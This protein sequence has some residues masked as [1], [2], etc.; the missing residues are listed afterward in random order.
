[1]TMTFK[2]AGLAAAL[3][4]TTALVAPSA[5][6]ADVTPSRSAATSGPRSSATEMFAPAA[7]SGLNMRLDVGLATG[8]TSATS[9]HFVLMN[10]TTVRS[11]LPAVADSDGTATDNQARFVRT[12]PP[13]ASVGGDYDGVLVVF[14]STDVAD[15]VGAGNQAAII[16]PN[17]TVTP[18]AD[19]AA[20]IAAAQADASLITKVNADYA[21][22]TIKTANKAGNGLFATFNAVP[23]NMPAAN[24]SAAAHLRFETAAGVAQNPLVRVDAGTATTLGADG[25]LTYAFSKDGTA[26]AIDIDAARVQLADA[27]TATSTTLATLTD[28]AGNGVVL[29]GTSINVPVT[30]LAA[31]ALASGTAKAV[32]TTAA[33]TIYASNGTNTA[34]VTVRFASNVAGGADNFTANA[35]VEDDFRIAPAGRVTVNALNATD[36]N[37][38]IS[39]TTSTLGDRF[40]YGADGKLYVFDAAQVPA[41]EFDPAN[42]TANGGAAVTVAVRAADTAANRL[43]TVVGAQQLAAG[44]SLDAGTPLAGTAPA[45]TA[46]TNDFDASGTLDGAKLTFGAPINATIPAASGAI[47]FKRGGSVTTAADV[48]ATTAELVAG[49]D[50][51]VQLKSTD[52]AIQALV[53]P[54]TEAAARTSTGSTGA[55]GTT[56]IPFDVALNDSTIAYTNVYAA[57]GDRAGELAQVRDI[58]A[59]TT[60]GTAIT[61]GAAPILKSAKLYTPTGSAIEGN[62]ELTFSEAMQTIAA[63]DAKKFLATPSGTLQVDLVNAPNAGDP[64]AVD[65]AKLA[66]GIITLTGVDK[67]ILDTLNVA[68]G[69]GVAEGNNSVAVATG[70]SFQGA[71]NNKVAPKKVTPGAE[72]LKETVK[73]DV[74]AT[75]LDATGKNVTDILVFLTSNV[76][77]KVATGAS[78]A[79][80][81]DVDLVGTPAV[82]DI[83]PASVSVTDNIL[84]IK[85]AG[86]GLTLRQLD[87]VNGINVDYTPTA[88]TF[89]HKVGDDTNKITAQNDIQVGMPQQ[90]RNIFSMDLR[91]R[92][93]TT[94]EPATATT[95]V[96]KGSIVRADVVY[97][98]KTNQVADRINVT[99]PCDCGT[100]GTS[101]IAGT[102][103]AVVDTLITNAKNAG[104]I[105][106][107]GY[108]VVTKTSNA[109][110]SND[111]AGVTA[112]VAAAPAA[113]A[114]GVVSYPISID[115]RNGRITSAERRISG[116]VYFDDNAAGNQYKVET[117]STSYGI[118]D[119]DGNYR[120]TVGVEDN[121][122]NAFVSLA[123]KRPNKTW[124]L[125]SSA[126][127]SFANHIPFKTDMLV[128]SATSDRTHGAL[129]GLDEFVKSGG[130]NGQGV[131][132]MRLD[133]IATT[134]V[135]KV[136][137]TSGASWQTV[138]FPGELARSRSLNDFT[139]FTSMVTINQGSGAPI[140]LWSLD[141]AGTT[142]AGANVEDE[143]FVLWG[144]RA[145]S[146][147]E[148]G[149]SQIQNI[150][151]NFTSGK[152]LAVRFGADT[153]GTIVNTGTARTDG[154]FYMVDPTKSVATVNLPAGWSLLTA[155]KDEDL[156]A[157]D[158]KD[159]LAMVVEAGAGK[160][161]RTWIK[162]AKGNLL[163]SMEKGKAY[164]VYLERAVNNAWAN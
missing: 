52:A 87:G 4:A 53:S 54:A 61:D 83:R 143:A 36:A 140:G 149:A 9:V 160:Q 98:T 118:V 78:L 58:H 49:S 119:A 96:E 10:G 41:V 122:D 24:S 114:S 25:I 109:A 46:S 2:K 123:V 69:V 21:G 91:G 5:F 105:S 152:G 132:N 84:T 60:Y 107:N 99:V 72:A 26:S 65:G 144:N 89:L 163:N 142:A 56:Q 77:A 127:K 70:A 150:R 75:V 79:D 138:G 121:V 153:A 137:G 62:V 68:N 139:A 104:Q 141:R 39:L 23:A 93:T 97:F 157:M 13:A 88:T 116:T 16:A 35:G 108:L 133:A 64:I 92:L 74:G 15:F 8:S 66:D 90:T 55:A 85:L 67:A 7:G 22:L 33:D 111:D 82:A 131:F 6:A 120:V 71:D 32:V 37:V 80:V 146:D 12:M 20:A 162:G 14:E 11:Q 155:E 81:F 38:A 95:V 17:G 128:A 103:T 159:S 73:F 112:A 30:A 147:F 51:I 113:A 106:A 63:D 164:F 130:Y 3:A 136:G 40:F 101:T 48:V 27:T 19:V 59:N 1:M 42:P 29:N 161:T 158:P 94:G 129:R 86:N 57:T 154:L 124:T 125:L 102:G 134:N 18:Y 50:K 31:P 44:A 148:F 151:S 145:A 135:A 34:T 28:T 76:A 45:P 100:N 156:A 115:V 43:R 47:V 117:A 110:D 126:D